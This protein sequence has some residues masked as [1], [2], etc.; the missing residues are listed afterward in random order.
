M[1]NEDR[2][3][4]LPVDEDYPSAAQAV[5]DAFHDAIDGEYVD[6]KFVLSTNQMLA[7]ALRAVVQQCVYMDD[8]GWEHM[9]PEDVL[10]IANELDG[11]A[12]T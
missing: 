6:G 4:R 10:E 2:A 3:G 1:A 9:D 5:M 12:A 7:A 8:F 11:G